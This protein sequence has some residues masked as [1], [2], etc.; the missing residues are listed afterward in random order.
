MKARGR[1]GSGEQHALALR[2][3]RALVAALHQSARAVEA[4]SGV[5]N[6]QLFILRELATQDGLS[7]NELA[8]RALTGQNTISMVVTRLGNRGLVGRHRAA[9]DGRRVVVSL[10]PTG[11]RL[12]RWAPEPPTARVLT[13]LIRMAP[14]EVGQLARGLLAL[15]DAMGTPASAAGMLF[16][17]NG[18]P[19]WHGPSH[20]APSRTHRTRH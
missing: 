15:T 13:A 10:T 1:G 5:T 9:D 6:A 14:V 12:V 4:R 7:I 19:A 11:R 8:A 20:S 18:A 3:I 16:E 17:Q 2:C